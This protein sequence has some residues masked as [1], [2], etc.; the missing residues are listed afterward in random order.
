MGL[1]PGIVDYPENR[2]FARIRFRDGR[3]NRCLGLRPTRFDLA[4]AAPPSEG[5]QTIELKPRQPGAWILNLR[6]DGL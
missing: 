2:R 6:S 4:A 1:L 5:N 3:P